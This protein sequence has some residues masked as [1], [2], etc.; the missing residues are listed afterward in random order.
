MLRGRE[1][2]RDNFIKQRKHVMI[3][4]E[5]LDEKHS[6]FSNFFYYYLKFFSSGI[7]FATSNYNRKFEKYSFNL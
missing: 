7:G 5:L 6:K 4:I 3:K 2:S 1:T